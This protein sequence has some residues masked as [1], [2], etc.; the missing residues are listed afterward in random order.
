M[1]IS[2]SAL[3]INGPP[4]AKI[5]DSSEILTSSLEISDLQR[6]R[7]GGYSDLKRLFN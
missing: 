4:R 5:L 7:D 1:S 6:N 3:L 2:Q